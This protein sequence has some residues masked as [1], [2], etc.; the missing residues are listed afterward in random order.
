MMRNCV[1]RRRL[2]NSALIGSEWK[3]TY[4]RGVETTSTASGGDLLKSCIC[5][6]L[7][8]FI[9]LYNS[10]T[11]LASLPNTKFSPNFDYPGSFCNLA[12]PCT[13][14]LALFCHSNRYQCHSAFKPLQP[15][16]GFIHYLTRCTNTS[17]TIAGLLA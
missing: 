16:K 17:F 15:K 5:K 2:I 14:M 1:L 9:S 3:C 12:K 7:S 4:W 13:W 10:K 11:I 6:L 8:F